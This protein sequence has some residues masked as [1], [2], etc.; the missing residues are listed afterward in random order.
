MISPM[1]YN[2]SPVQPLQE[3]VIWESNIRRRST[4]SAFSD[5]LGNTNIEAFSAKLCEVVDT[6]GSS[7]RETPQ[8]MNLGRDDRIPQSLSVLLAS[9]S[10]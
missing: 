5:I 7:L 10:T 9:R 6:W 3:F 4:R 1:K 8:I 2:H